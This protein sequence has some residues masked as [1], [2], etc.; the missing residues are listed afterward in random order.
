MTRTVMPGMA[1]GSAPLR[2]IRREA[3]GSDPGQ[4]GPVRQHLQHRQVH[5]AFARHSTCTPAASTSASSP[6]DRKCR[7]ASNR[8]PGW[9]LPSSWRVSGCSPVASGDIPA[10]STARVAFAEADTRICG[11]GPRQASL[12][13]SRTPPVLRRV[14]RSGTSRPRPPAAS[15]ART[16]APAPPGSGRPPPP[17]RPHHL[18]PAAGAR[19]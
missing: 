8:S 11:K 9:S 17:A 15:R 12:P 2:S 14:G 7:S 13:G 3:A 6:W 4:P 18:Q 19:R 5:I 10:P 1:F 16:R